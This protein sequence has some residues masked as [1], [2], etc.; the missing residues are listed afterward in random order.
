MEAIKPSQHEVIITT[1][2]WRVEVSLSRPKNFISMSG[3]G[4]GKSD[5]TRRTGEFMN[6]YLD[7]RQLRELC[8]MGTAIL[9]LPLSWW[10]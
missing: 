9:R 7:T 8:D 1:W 5:E 3:K 10:R 4:E 2:A 6:K